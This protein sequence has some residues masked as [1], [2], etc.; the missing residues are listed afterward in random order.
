MTATCP[1]EAVLRGML[2]SSLPEPVQAEVVCHLDSCS[3]CQV[4]LEQ[5]AAVLTSVWTEVERAAEQRF[6]AAEE[7]KLRQM[8][9]LLHGLHGWISRQP[10][11]EDLPAMLA[12]TRVERLARGLP[13]NRPR[14]NPSL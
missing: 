2:D 7:S 13:I 9:I 8:I 10:E 3:N 14:R 12:N 4:K 1:E 11:G 6:Y 5:L